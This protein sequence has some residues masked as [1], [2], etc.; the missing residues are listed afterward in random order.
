M[1]RNIVVIAWGVVA[2][3]GKG[4]NLIACAIV[5]GGSRWLD[6]ARRK[7]GVGSDLVRFIGL[8]KSASGLQK[9]IK[10][11]EDLQFR[12]VQFLLSVLAWRHCRSTMLVRD[13]Q[14]NYLV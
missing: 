4:E 2:I 13:Y 8:D 11:E 10:D 3:N 12:L 14:T 9:K 5:G 1:V 7:L 6:I